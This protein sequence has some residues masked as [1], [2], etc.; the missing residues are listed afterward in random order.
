MNDHYVCFCV[1]G[2]LLPTRMPHLAHRTLCSSVDKI[3]ALPHVSVLGDRNPLPYNFTSS[4]S[5][6]D[7]DMYTVTI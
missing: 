4:I 5:L 1:V 3:M 2:D 7:L 6:W